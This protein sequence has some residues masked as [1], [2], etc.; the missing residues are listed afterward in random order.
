VATEDPEQRERAMRRSLLLARIGV[1]AWAL[2]VVLAVVLAF[3]LQPSWIWVI[4]AVFG[5]ARLVLDL[6][7]TIA[8]GAALRELV[9][10]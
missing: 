8:V 2:V 9:E 1:A 5:A 4:L 10:A 6:R 7:R 3:Q